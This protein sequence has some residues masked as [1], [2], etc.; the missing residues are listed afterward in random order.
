MTRPNLKAIMQRAHEIA[1]TLEG[2]YRARLALGMRAAWAEAKGNKVIDM[3]EIEHALETL[4]ARLAPFAMKIGSLFER[5]SHDI[6]R[7][8]IPF[9][10]PLDQLL[11]RP[12]I[13]QPMHVLAAYVERIVSGELVLAET[14]PYERPTP[15]L[16]PANDLA[17]LANS[18]AK[19]NAYASFSANGDPVLVA[20]VGAFV[21]GDSYAGHA[22]E[23]IGAA[24][25]RH[26]RNMAYHYITGRS[27]GWDESDGPGTG[28]SWGVLCSP[29]E[30]KRQF[31]A[32]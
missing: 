7:T 29:S 27:F 24:F 26:G 5:P 6:Y 17:S 16:W 2:D 3:T 14:G 1:R 12:F 9:S 8:D 22:I 19:N 18:R 30:R 10:S 32:S 28:D 21:V 25:E 23:R 4:N 15:L 11:L 20:E 13:D 31:A